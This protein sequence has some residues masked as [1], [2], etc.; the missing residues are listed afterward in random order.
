[1]KNGTKIDVIPRWSSDLNCSHAQ[2]TTRS[3]LAQLCHLSEWVLR[4]REHINFGLTDTHNYNRKWSNLRQTKHLDKFIRWYLLII[5]QVF[6]ESAERE[7][8]HAG[9]QTMQA[10]MC[11][12]TA[13]HVHCP[14]SSM[15]F[16]LERSYWRKTI[17]LCFDF[18]SGSLWLFY[19]NKQTWLSYLKWIAST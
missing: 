4:T 12:S 18:G 11:T 16:R 7:R 10:Y 8:E 5:I 9:M 1:M 3:K 2:R 17:H 13:T 14:C 6:L 15:Q 19:S